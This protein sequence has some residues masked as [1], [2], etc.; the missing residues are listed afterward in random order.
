MDKCLHLLTKGVL[1]M[2][3]MVQ[4]SVQRCQKS[5]RWLWVTAELQGGLYPP[6]QIIEP[7]SMTMPSCAAQPG[8]TVHRVEVDCLNLSQW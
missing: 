3:H 5:N 1:T 7:C 2:A 4:C 6:G 8:L